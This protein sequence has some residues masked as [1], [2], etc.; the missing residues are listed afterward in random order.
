MAAPEIDT[1]KLFDFAGMETNK[2]E[3]VA[4]N[5]F[6]AMVQPNIPGAEL[7]APAADNQPAAASN[8][9]NIESFF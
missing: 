1:S 9:N 6:D 7:Q 2:T 5:T 4:D 8:D 3:S